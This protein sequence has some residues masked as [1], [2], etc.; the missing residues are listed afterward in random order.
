MPKG[1]TQRDRKENAGGGQML[2]GNVCV[3]Q[4]GV[5]SGFGGREWE[6]A[7]AYELSM[8]VKVVTGQFGINMYLTTMWNS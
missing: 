1:E 3:L 2:A 8:H 7:Q 6:G 5:S 4:D